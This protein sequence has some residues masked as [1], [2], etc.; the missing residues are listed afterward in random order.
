MENRVAAVYMVDSYM[1]NGYETSTGSFRN[2][3]DI[4]ND[5][6]NIYS[7]DYKDYCNL[8]E[9]LEDYFC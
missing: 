1:V 5:A 9:Y 3:S 2:L 4:I 8:V 6:A 7:K